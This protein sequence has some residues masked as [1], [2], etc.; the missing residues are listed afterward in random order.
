MMIAK[1]TPW[2]LAARPKT[3]TA[4]LIPVLVGSSLAIQ[5]LGFIDWKISFCALMA[6]ISIQI[7]TNLINDAL[8]FKKGADTAERMGP[9]R[10]TQSGALKL[11]QVFLGGILCFLVALIFSIPLIMIGGLP[12]A[13]IM[14]LS[15]LCGYLYTGGPFPLA[16]LGLGDLFVLLFFGFI[17]TG[18]VFYL[19]GGVLGFNALLAGAEIGLLSTVMIAINNLRDMKGDKKAQK[20][21]L[22]VRFG[23]TFGKIEITLLILLPF[24]L[25][26][27]WIKE[28]NAFAGFL[29]LFI[30]PTALFIIRNIW[31]HEPGP[32]YNHFLGFAALLHVLFGTL[33]SIGLIYG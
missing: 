4:A 17:A 31:Q 21:T 24:A 7:G 8:D 25:N 2:I 19:Q 6:A 29:P 16:Y 9:V 5:E 28:G 15:V 18:T 10:A 26:L 12:I 3:L 20:L 27:F 1:W 13:L 33:L 11:T 14:I 23:K 22:P 30:L 32:L